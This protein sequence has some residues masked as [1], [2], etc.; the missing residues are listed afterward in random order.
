MAKEILY[1]QRK[2]CAGSQASNSVMTHIP[3][4]TTIPETSDNCGEARAEG[5]LFCRGEQASGR[6]RDHPA[7]GHT[8]GRDDHRRAVFDKNEGQ[9]ARDP[10]MSSTKKGLIFGI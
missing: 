1:G 5:A 9:S 4:E 6:S 3:D 7:L 10:E 2:P 8:R